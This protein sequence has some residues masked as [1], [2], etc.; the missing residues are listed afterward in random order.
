MI[1]REIKVDF[2]IHPAQEGLPDYGMSIPSG[3]LRL[4]KLA[5][6]KIGQTVWVELTYRRSRFM[7]L[8]LTVRGWFITP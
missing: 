2:T 3:R 6:R 1:N 5:Y 8:Y 7:R 4:D